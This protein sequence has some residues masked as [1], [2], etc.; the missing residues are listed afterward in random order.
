[1]NLNKINRHNLIKYCSSK[2]ICEYDEQDEIYT[3][4]VKVAIMSLGQGEVKKCLLEVQS[5]HF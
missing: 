3:C 2:E 1:M 4:D 5:S